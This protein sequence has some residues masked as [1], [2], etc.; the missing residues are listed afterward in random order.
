MGFLLKPKSSLRHAR[1]LMLMNLLVGLE[2]Q[3]SI[4]LKE[5]QTASSKLYSFVILYIATAPSLQKKQ[6]VSVMKRV[7]YKKTKKGIGCELQSRF[8][9]R[10]CVTL[11][12]RQPGPHARNSRSNSPACWRWTRPWLGGATHTAS[13]FTLH[14]SIS[15]SKTWEALK[16][17]PSGSTPHGTGRSASDGC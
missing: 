5:K 11:N 2:L 8:I 14:W 10:P 1:A 13:L 15:Y 3:R 12:H 9:D 17:W 4:T 16:I 6:L 7:S